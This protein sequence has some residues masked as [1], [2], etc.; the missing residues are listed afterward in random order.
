MPLI[1]SVG[2]GSVSSCRDL[3]GRAIRFRLESELG[4]LSRLRF[5][6]AVAGGSAADRRIIAVAVKLAVCNAE[7]P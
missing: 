7:T 2:S 6:L 1:G 4:A 5:P 3:G